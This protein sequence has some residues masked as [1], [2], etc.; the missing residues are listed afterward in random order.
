MFG[1]AKMAIIAAMVAMTAVSAYALVASDVYA[2][3]SR[4]WTPPVDDQITY[5]NGELTSKMNPT[6]P[7]EYMDCMVTE[8]TAQQGKFTMLCSAYEEIPVTQ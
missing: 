1:N 6:Y 4:R 2:P 3:S 5:Q 7:V 8:N